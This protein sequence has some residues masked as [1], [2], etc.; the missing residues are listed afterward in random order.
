MHLIRAFILGIAV[1]VAN[2]FVSQA[3]ENNTAEPAEIPRHIVVPIEF[4]ASGIWVTSARLNDNTPLQLGVDLAA[5]NSSIR[6]SIVDSEQLSEDDLNFNVYGLIGVETA[7]SVTSKLTAGHFE[8]DGSI[9]VIED[10]QALA[11]PDID[12]LA[13]IDLLFGGHNFR[14]VLIDLREG[15]IE[16]SNSLKLLDLKGRLPW[17]KQTE[18]GRERGFLSF[19][20]RFDG[21]SG[22]AVIDTGINFLVANPRLGE[23]LERRREV[24]EHIYTDA[25]GEEAILHTARVLR[26]AGAGMVWTGST[27]V[28]HDSPAIE[29]IVPADKPAMLLG[30]VHLNNNIIVIDTQKHRIAVSPLRDFRTD[31]CS[32]NLSVCFS[33]STPQ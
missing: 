29:K 5:Q 26:I 13:G 4:H 2:T 23:K 30:L 11:A 18:F 17:K 12:G 14:Y 27:A 6:R 31:A 15:I 32:S 1:F 10:P 19:P 21:I 24:R 22:V 28:V 9:I 33:F 16:A 8:H 3:T 20:A 7:P 25:N